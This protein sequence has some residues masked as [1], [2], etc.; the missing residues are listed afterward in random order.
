MPL[1]IYEKNVALSDFGVEGQGRI[2]PE[3]FINR[4]APINFI[5][6]FNNQAKR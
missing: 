2:Y 4:S 3:G 1:H 5:N 6:F